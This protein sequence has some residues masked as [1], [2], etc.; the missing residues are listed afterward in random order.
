[1]FAPSR[2]RHSFAAIAT[3]FALAGTGTVA[4][5]HTPVPGT[6]IVKKS[7]RNGCSQ[8]VTQKDHRK[9]AVAVYKRPR[10]S[11]QARHELRRLRLCQ[12]TAKA[13][14]NT[15]ELERALL[16]DRRERQLIASMGVRGIGLQEAAKRG[17]T[18]S[19][20]NCLDS[21]WNRESGW[22]HRADNPTSDAY[23]IPQALPGAKMASAGSDW[24]TNPRTQIRWGLGY[25]AG[26]YGSPCGA[27]AHSQSTGWY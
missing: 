25:I 3:V 23:G 11:D 4:P 20:W 1:M 10:I 26:R 19:E 13:G 5:I 22:N 9:Y 2:L 17:W 15:R 8:L 18:G 7:L 6:A 24:A 12:H 21:L 14:R 27:W 16:R